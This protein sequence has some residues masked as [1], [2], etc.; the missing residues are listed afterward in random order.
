MPS[1]QQLTVEFGDIVARIFLIGLH[2]SSHF[3]DDR[4]GGGNELRPRNFVP[5]V[6][7][8]QPEDGTNSFARNYR[9]YLLGFNCQMMFQRF[10]VAD[11]V[12]QQN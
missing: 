4:F 7:M 8:P 11:N 1:F 6:G 12:A 2:E 9:E 3:G 5:L 10:D